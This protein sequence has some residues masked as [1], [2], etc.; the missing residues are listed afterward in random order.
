MDNTYSKELIQVSNEIYLAMRTQKYIVP[1]LVT[2]YN[3]L[4]SKEKAERGKNK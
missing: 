4:L 2:K 3:I 1:D